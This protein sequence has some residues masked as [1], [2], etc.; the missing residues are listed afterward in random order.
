M[1]NQEISLILFKISG[2][3]LAGIF[4]IF[5]YHNTRFSKKNKER[6]KENK[7][8]EENYRKYGVYTTDPDII[9][10]H[11]EEKKKEAEQEEREKKR[12]I[13]KYGKG[14]GIKI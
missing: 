8:S 6:E 14:K 13:K 4:L 1:V 12:L 10:K 3:L 2:F 9:A 11:Q 7:L 5:V